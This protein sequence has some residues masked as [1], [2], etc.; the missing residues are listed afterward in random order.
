LCYD[1][2][3]STLNTEAELRLDGESHQLRYAHHICTSGELVR[4]LDEAGFAVKALYGDTGDAPFRP[5]SPRLLLVAM[6]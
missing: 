6:E 5:G 1:A 2:F 3:T 4:A